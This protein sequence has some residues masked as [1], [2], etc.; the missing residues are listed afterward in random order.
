MGVQL[1]PASAQA[2]TCPPVVGV[3][4]AGRVERA[5]SQRAIEAHRPKGGK[6]VA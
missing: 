3:V 4:Y 5:K 2:Y 1:S 6:P